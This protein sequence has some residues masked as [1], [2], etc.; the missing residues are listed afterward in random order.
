MF[1]TQDV[2]NIFVRN[3]RKNDLKMR[4][5]DRTSKWGVKVIY[6]VHRNI[7]QPLSGQPISAWCVSETIS[8]NRKATFLRPHGDLTGLVSDALLRFLLQTIYRFSELPSRRGALVC[9]GLVC[10]GLV[11]TG[12]VCAGFTLQS[13]FRSASGMGYS[14]FTDRNLTNLLP[15]LAAALNSS[16]ETFPSHSI[17]RCIKPYL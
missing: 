2:G 3:S 7:L 4:F 6:S 16:V 14:P 11:C 12:L 10:A 5:Y 15:A 8:E 9:A 1:K 17:Y 13:S